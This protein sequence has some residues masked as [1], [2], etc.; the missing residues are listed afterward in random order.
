VIEFAI[1]APNRHRVAWIVVLI[2]ISLLIRSGDSPPKL[3]KVPGGETDKSVAQPIS[4]ATHANLPP[5]AYVI[6]IGPDG[7]VT[8]VPIPA[9]G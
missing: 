6:V 5:Q 2:G 3:E 4:G 9:M 1:S 7:R 8:T